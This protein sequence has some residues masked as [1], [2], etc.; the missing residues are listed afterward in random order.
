M[1]HRRLEDAIQAVAQLAR[2]GIKVRLLL[3]G[4]ERSYPQYV[5]SLKALANRL[6][7]DHEVTFTG[8]IPDDEIRDLY[9]A[10]DAFLFPNHQQTWGLAVFE[11]MA[12][13][14]PVLVSRGAGAHE[15]LTDGRNA[16]LFSPRNPDELAAKI[17][18]LVTNPQLKYEIARNGTRIVCETYNWAQFADQI[19]REC[20][21]LMGQE[22]SGLTRFY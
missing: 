17:E 6:G 2:G 7:V 3:A 21:D 16:L 14:C 1:P 9:A 11:A 5:K 15:V 12:C 13:G 19:Q 22:G 4:S 8:K 20:Q 18:C 10:C